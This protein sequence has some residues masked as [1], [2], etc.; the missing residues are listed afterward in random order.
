MRTT[1]TIVLCLEKL[2]SKVGLCL[3]SRHGIPVG[4]FEWAFVSLTAA[5]VI[6]FAEFGGQI[7]LEQHL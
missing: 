7:T 1:R 4:V 6:G 2:S 5:W 3:G